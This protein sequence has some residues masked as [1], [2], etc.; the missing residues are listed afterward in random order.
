MKTVHIF[1]LGLAAC[2]LAAGQEG[3]PAAKPRAKMAPDLPAITILQADAAPTVDG[4]LDDPCWQKAERSQRFADEYGF[5]VN[6]TTTFQI[7]QKDD[8]LYLAIRAQYDPEL[9][10]RDKKK[11]TRS[12]AVKEHDGSLWY[13]EEIELFFDFDNDDTT[14]YY[15]IGITPSDVTGDWFCPGLHDNDGDW[16][17]QYTVKS[18]WSEQEWTIEYALPLKMFDRATG[19]YENFGLMI[20]RVDSVYWNVATWTPLRTEGFHFPHRYGEARGLKGPGVKANEPGLF[21][22]PYLR[23]NDRVIRATAATPVVPEKPPTFVKPPRIKES[24][25]TVEIEFEA[26]A[27]T[28]VA[29]WVEDAQGERVRHLA[30]GLLGE[31]APPPLQPKSLKQK[32][33][34][35]WLNDAG[36]PLAKGAYTVKVGLG[37]QG[38]LDR[39]LG[40]DPAPKEIQG[41]ATDANGRLY[42]VG[43]VR[44]EWTDL[45]VYDR[46]G[47]YAQTLFPPPASVPP[48]KLPGMNVIDLGRDGQVRYGAH[49]LNAYLPSL[50][51]PMPHTPLVN[52]QGQ[53]IIYG[54]EYLGGPTRFYKINPDG[55]LPPDW[56]G[57]YVKEF[58]WLQYYDEWGKRFHFAL[59]PQDENTIYLSGIKDHH[60]S[61][62]MQNELK[63]KRYT[64]WNAIMRVHWGQDAPLETAIGKANFT[65]RDGGNGPGEFLDPQ[66]IAFDRAGHL[67]V[68][69]RG[70]QRLQ[71]F[72]AKGQ[73][74][75]QCPHPAPYEVRHDLKT[76]AAYVMGAAD[77]KVTLRKYTPGAAGAPPTPVGEPLVLGDQMKDDQ[78]QGMNYWWTMALDAGA[79]PPALWVV[80]G[81][82]ARPYQIVRVVDQ[83]AA[84]APPEVVIGQTPPPTYAP[85]AVGWDSDIVAAGHTWLDGNTGE[86]IGKR[87][88]GD[89]VWG[90]RDGTW[91]IRAGFFTE[92]VSFFA[93]DWPT[94]PKA[95][96]LRAWDIV[97][98]SLNR[99]GRRGFC[100]APNGDVYVARYYNMQQEAS[101]RGGMEGTDWHVAVDHYSGD[102]KL[103][104]QR[105]V[106]ELSHAAAGP[107]VDRRGN[108]YV[109][110]NIGRRLGEFY[111]PDIAANLPAWA[112]KHRIDWEK[113]RRGEALSVGP[114]KFISDPLVKS[115]GTVY[116]F[117]PQGGGLIWRVAQ[118]PYTPHEP[119][120]KEGGVFGQGQF[121]DWHYP[122]A[123]IPARPATHWSSTWVGLS[124]SLGV[125]P[126]WQE[127][128]E[129][130]FLGVSPMWGR[131]NKGHSS[132]VCLTCRM[133]VDDFGRAFVPA[134]HRSCVRVLDSAGNE[135]ARLGRYANMDGGVDIPMRVP[136][137]VALSKRYVYVAELRDAR[138]VRL[139][140]GYAAEHTAA[141][142]MK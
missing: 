30:A 138:V 112:P 7:C 102:G 57:P 37:L 16:E 4:K 139:K 80:V 23:V 134:A 122:P 116:K 73:F 47:K 48:E 59:D 13:G 41:I 10:E 106:Y 58:T 60:R 51:Q 38:K 64:W 69:D 46:A 125:F 44:D 97:P 29:V 19:M 9:I 105:V 62:I 83:G 111:E 99:A 141:V 82:R 20:G 93:A 92:K 11:V 6:L 40:W 113:L 15:Q 91:A 52:R 87:P 132:C 56:K 137:H 32:L 109:L 53:V 118:G 78:K 101:G 133:D 61:E 76:G 126:R 114:E 5:P 45:I 8:V 98:P 108:I 131:Y 100:V 50:D 140:L 68:C 14:G 24:R 63:A 86:V 120:P 26:S 128:V 49:R 81:S 39:Q 127:G 84:F 129:W 67:W 34:W 79:T 43:G 142:T 77:G 119:K 25:K 33:V 35:D 72:D 55:S 36:Q 135:I 123:P 107:V 31:K 117:G 94:Q 22:S 12:D 71:A 2:L 54:G 115:V 104:R 89:E 3:A 110:D 75:W 103:Q 21:R 130:E 70:N 28:D 88:H 136:V 1:W 42:I 18:Q 121:L 27:P 90:A 74:L 65:G 124:N 96:P 66:G 85:L 95:K 17:P